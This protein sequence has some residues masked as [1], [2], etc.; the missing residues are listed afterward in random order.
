[1]REGMK[2]RAWDGGCPAR[3]R[4][5]RG[6]HELAEFDRDENALDK[7][8][9]EQAAEVDCDELLDLVDG[10]SGAGGADGADAAVDP[11]KAVAARNKGIVRTSVIGIVANVFLAAFKAVIGILS[12]S[13]AITLDAVNNLSDATSSVITIVGTKLAGKAPDR[14]HPFGYGR[15]EYLTTI[16]V[17][18]IVL[19]AGITS[20]SESVQQIIEPQTPSYAIPSLII[21]GAAVAVK[22][23]LGLFTRASGKRFKSG[24]LVASGTD[25]LTDSIISAATLVAALVFVN[26]GISL[27]AWLGVIIALVII[28]AG[29]DMLREVL[30][31]ILGERVESDVSRGVKQTVASVPG[32]HGAYDLFLEDYG[33]DTL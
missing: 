5:A 3:A 18:A 17:S 10:M 33:P 14:K 24:A 25:A 22:V 12:N 26:T 4:N 11:T 29:I 28:K 2:T 21:V 6:V 20:L 27:E 7:N 23:A 15:I 19:W 32:V 8:V 9:N 30:S 16:I 13:I 31:K 1:M